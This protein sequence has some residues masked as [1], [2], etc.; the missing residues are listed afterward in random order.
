MAGSE[1]IWSVGNL[2]IEN[3]DLNPNYGLAV[4]KGYQGAKPLGLLEFIGALEGA[5][6]LLRAML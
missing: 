6:F 2:V 1:R 4:D 3:Q 5:G